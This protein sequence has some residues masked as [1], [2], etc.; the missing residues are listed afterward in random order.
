MA[1]FRALRGASGV[2]WGNKKR[3]DFYPKIRYFCYKNF[4]L[5]PRMAEIRQFS[6]WWKYLILIGRLCTSCLRGRSF[7][8]R[9]RFWSI[10]ILNFKWRKI[11]FSMNG[12][13]PERWMNKLAN[14]NITVL[15]LNRIWSGLTIFGSFK[16]DRVSCRPASP[17]TWGITFLQP[18]LSAKRLLNDWRHSWC[19]YDVFV[20]VPMT[21]LPA[22]RQSFGYS[23]LPSTLG[24][25]FF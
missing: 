20:G 16:A 17:V 2:M 23:T 25:L 13:L 24:K 12:M 19:T 4:F 7:W 14:G 11:C 10:F 22:F 21:S 15:S 9:F 6:F 8:T 5:S 1:D 3:S 18:E